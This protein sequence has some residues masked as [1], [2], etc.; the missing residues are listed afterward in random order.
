[1]LRIVY[2]RDFATRSVRI[3]I[4]IDD[5]DMAAANLPTIELRPR[6]YLSLPSQLRNLASVLDTMEANLQAESDMLNAHSELDV[7]ELLNMHEE[8]T[9]DLPTDEDE[10]EEV[11]ME[12]EEGEEDEDEEEDDDEDMED[13]DDDD[14]DEEAE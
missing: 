6:E 9:P 10:L 4:I 1:M 7:L 13:E 8:E 14:E 11:D 5:D 2:S 3:Q 12:E